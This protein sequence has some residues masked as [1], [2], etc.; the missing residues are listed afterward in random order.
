MDKT[1]L[2]SF[3]PAPLAGQHEAVGPHA[4]STPSP[5]SSKARPQLPPPWATLSRLL[6]AS[7]LLAQALGPLFERLV[8]VARPFVPAFRCLP[9][10]CLGEWES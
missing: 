5:T 7:C 1:D 10:L 8:T 9:T 4:S 2:R 3:S 6:D